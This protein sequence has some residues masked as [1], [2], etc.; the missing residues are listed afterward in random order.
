MKQ[1]QVFSI[2]MMLQK[3]PRHTWKHWN[4]KFYSI[5]RIL[6][7]LLLHAITCFDRCIRNRWS[8][9]PVIWRS[10][11]LDRYVD[12]L[13]RYEEFFRLEIRIWGKVV[14]QRF[15]VL[16]TLKY[17]LF[18]YNKTSNFLK[19]MANSVQFT[20]ITYFVFIRYKVIST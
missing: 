19:K 12:R 6:Q 13:K 16:W 14:G 15:A 17:N 5:C 4:E 9:L 1:S 18:F 7:T 20:L 2:D 8:S 3:W 11:K 10:N